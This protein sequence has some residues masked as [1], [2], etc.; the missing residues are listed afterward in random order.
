MYFT[1]SSYGVIMKNKKVRRE[2]LIYYKV[3]LCLQGLNAEDVGG[4]NSSDNDFPSFPSL[5]HNFIEHSPRSV[6][7]MSYFAFIL[8]TT[9]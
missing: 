4:G 2:A 6:L 3:V 7:Y 8:T 5:R 9:F 1:F